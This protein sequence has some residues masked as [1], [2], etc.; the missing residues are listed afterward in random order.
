MLEAAAIAGAFIAACRDELDAPKPG[1]VHIFAAGHGMA[2]EEFRAS[3]AAAARFI[4]QAGAGVGARIDAAMAATWAAVAKNTNLGIIL[5]CAPLAVAAERGG[6]L[7]EGLRGVL[8]HLTINDAALAFRA[9]RLASPAGLGNS[10]AHDVRQEPTA[11]LLEAMRAAAGHDRIAWNY[12]HGFDDILQSGQHVLAQA[13]QLRTQVQASAWRPVLNLYLHFL[14]AHPDSHIARKFGQDRARAVQLEAAAFCQRAMSGLPDAA[15]LPGLL[16][17]DAR[18]KSAGLNPG[19][20]ADLTVAALF[21]ER[22][23]RGAQSA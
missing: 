21:A 22:L 6:P 4:A 15:L 3:A 19:T 23:I 11:T 7:P 13:R 2:V 14:S 9:I 16:A 10:D 8:D 18:L 12:A 5:L 20:S 1:N 17:F